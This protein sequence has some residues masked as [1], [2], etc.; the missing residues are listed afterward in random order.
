MS[1]KVTTLVGYELKKG[2]KVIERLKPDVF[3]KVEISNVELPLH[4]T[5]GLT[6]LAHGLG[7]KLVPRYKRS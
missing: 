1:K 2:R 6:Q 7:L 4:D 3:G 5:K